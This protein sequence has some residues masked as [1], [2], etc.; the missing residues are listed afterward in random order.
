MKN[1]SH[2]LIINGKISYYKILISW[3]III[4]L[5]NNSDRV[6]VEIL[7]LQRNQLILLWNNLFLSSSFGTSIENEDE[8]YKFLE[9]QYHALTALMNFA[10][11]Y[12][13]TESELKQTKKILVKISNFKYNI[14][15]KIVDNLLLQIELKVFM[16]YR[17]LL[18]KY[19]SD[20]SN[21]SLLLVLTK[22]ISN[23]DVFEDKNKNILTEFLKESKVD[24]TEMVVNDHL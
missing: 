15:G 7:S 1:T 9:I 14:G 20:F 22:N 18:Q 2:S 13:L 6:T 16:I 3:L 24:E 19:N 12:H 4:G 21:N 5:L 11:N 17:I 10:T 8:L 23:V